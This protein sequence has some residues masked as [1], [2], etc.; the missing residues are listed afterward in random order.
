MLRKYRKSNSSIKFCRKIPHSLFQKP[1][2]R[3]SSRKSKSS[4]GKATTVLTYTGFITCLP[5]IICSFPDT[6]IMLAPHFYVAILKAWFLQLPLLHS[7]CFLLIV[8]W[9]N[10][11]EIIFESQIWP[12][13][14]KGIDCLRFSILFIELRRIWMKRW[15][16]E[17]SN[18][19][20]SL[21]SLFA[22]ERAQMARLYHLHATTMI[23]EKWLSIIEELSHSIFWLFSIL[24]FLC[25]SSHWR[26]CKKYESKRCS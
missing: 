8:F 3:Q 14:K 23:G 5:V 18:D 25:F 4:N 21:F 22:G 15:L 1:V 11:K 16:V 9:S 19:G 13:L 7:S 6:K 20:M 12:W 10:N 26:P 24:N 2:P 17:E